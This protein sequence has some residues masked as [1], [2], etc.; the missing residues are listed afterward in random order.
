MAKVIIEDVELLPVPFRNARGLKSKFNA[1]GRRSI[2]IAIDQSVADELT[3]RGYN[4]RYLEPLNEGDPPK[5]ILRIIIKISP[6]SDE[7]SKPPTIWCIYGDRKVPLKTDN[8]D[9][10]DYLDVS[11]CDVVINGYE[12]DFNGRQGVSAYLDKMFAVVEQDD[13]DIKYAH[14]EMAGDDS[15]LD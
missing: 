14:F 13:L 3:G 12:Y 5:P 8:I 9:A 4:I 15:S 10:L 6:E 11:S 2:T 1:P 7:G